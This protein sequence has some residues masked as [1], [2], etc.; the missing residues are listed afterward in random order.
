MPNREHEIVEK[1]CCNDEY[2]KYDIFKTHIRVSTVLGAVASTVFFP[3]LCILF[4][5]YAYRNWI[6]SIVV[7]TTLGTTSCLHGS[8]KH[9]LN[10]QCT[11][12][13][14]CNINSI[15][16]KTKQMNPN[17]PLTLHFLQNT[18]VNLCPGKSEAIDINSYEDLAYAEFLKSQTNLNL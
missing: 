7:T 18:T 2:K 6:N 4:I 9:N 10:F 5:F 16:D 8:A 13:Q 1:S 15:G 17:L 3:L 14:G 11:V 12:P